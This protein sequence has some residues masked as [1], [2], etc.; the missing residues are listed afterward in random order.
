MVPTSRPETSVMQSHYTLR[1]RLKA[2]RSQLINILPSKKSVPIGKLVVAERFEKTLRISCSRQVHYV[3]NRSHSQCP[4][5]PESFRPLY[6]I[7][8]M[9]QM[10][11]CPF[12]CQALLC[13]WTARI[14]KCSPMFQS[15]IEHKKTNLSDNP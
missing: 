9:G 2:R 11:L 8:R 5:P 6:N 3:V 12:V 13:F 15:L 4:E 10:L 1:N 7:I 14:E